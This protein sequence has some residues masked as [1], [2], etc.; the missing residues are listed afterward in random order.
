MVLDCTISQRLTAAPAQTGSCLSRVLV[1]S[2]F[3]NLVTR[4]FPD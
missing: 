4:E 1:Q 2:Q 3:V